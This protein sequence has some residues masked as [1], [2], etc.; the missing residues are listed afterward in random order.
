MVAGKGDHVVL[1][2]VVSDESQCRPL[3]HALPRKRQRRRQ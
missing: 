2:L 3:R 1:L